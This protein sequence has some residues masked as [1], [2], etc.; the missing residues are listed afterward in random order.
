MINKK[1]ILNA[2]PSTLLI[3]ASLI[4][5]LGLSG[6]WLKSQLGINF[7]N[8]IS[9]SRH[10]PFNALAP[11]TVIYN[12]R[13]GIL[14]QDSFDSFSLFGNWKYLWMREEGNVT[15][16]YDSQGI[17]NTRCLLIKNN[18]PGSWSFSH[19][20]YVQVKEGDTFTF[21]VLVRLQGEN[22][23]AYAGVAAFDKRK[24]AISWNYFT[25]KTER[26]AEW[27]LLKKTFTIPGDISY[28][29]FRLSGSGAGTYR[30]DDVRFVK[31]S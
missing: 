16:E 25:E 17:D 18:S 6:Y 20:K 23:S 4:I 10:F 15:K 12:P 2:K 8:R 14:L 27:V 30:F 1:K 22:V 26:T 24:N 31:D 29:Q 19:K 3:T 5:L 11:H 21:T 28:I 13:P 9:L 7:S